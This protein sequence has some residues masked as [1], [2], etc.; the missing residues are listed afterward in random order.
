MNIFR[1]TTNRT[2]GILLDLEKKTMQFWLNGKEHVGR[3]KSLTEGYWVPAIRIGGIDN[4]V[5]L[6]PYGQFQQCIIPYSCS[7]PLPIAIKQDLESYLASWV[8]V[9]SLKIV[10]PFTNARDYLLSQ[11]ATKVEIQSVLA[12]LH[13]DGKPTGDVLVKVSD[14]IQFAAD[15]SSVSPIPTVIQA[16][17]MAQL[18]TNNKAS[19]QLDVLKACLKMRGEAVLNEA[20]EVVKKIVAKQ[21]VKEELAKLSTIAIGKIAYS[22]ASEEE[23][24]K[25]E[26]L[27]YTDKLLLVGKTSL[28]LLSREAEQ[29]LGFD[30]NEGASSFYRMSF[31]P[32]SSG[33]IIKLHIDRL[34]GIQLAS[35]MNWIEVHNGNYEIGD[36]LNSF[37]LELCLNLGNGKSREVLIPVSYLTAKIVVDVLMKSCLQALLVS[38]TDEKLKDSIIKRMESPSKI[39]KEEGKAPGERQA[40]LS[41]EDLHLMLSILAKLDEQLWCLAI[42]ESSSDEICALWNVNTS[43]I[44]T[45][46]GRLSS[47]VSWPTNGAV[48]LAEAGLVNV[49]DKRIMLKHFMEP[50][51]QIENAMQYDQRSRKEIWSL[52]EK[53]FPNNRQLRSEPCLNVPLSCT[54][55]YFPALR[56]TNMDKKP[57]EIT[58]VEYK[59]NNQYILTGSADG[60]VNIW[61][62]SLRLFKVVSANF[63]QPK[64]APLIKKTVVVP[65]TVTVAKETGDAGL[66][67][68]LFEVEEKQLWEE[69]DIELPPEEVKKEE[70]KKEEKKKEEPKKVVAPRQDFVDQL[71]AMGFPADLAKKALI[72]VNNESIE[73]ATEAVF[74][75][76]KKEPPRPP[77][78]KVEDK[79]MRIISWACPTCTLINVEGKKVCEVCS[80]EAPASA[81]IQASPNKEEKK[82]QQPEP[83]KEI[84]LGPTLKEKEETIQKERE[85][86]NLRKMEEEKLISS[87]QVKGYTMMTHN[88]YPAVPFTI[89]CALDTGKGC[90]IRVRTFKYSS[91]YLRSFITHPDSK[92]CISH[93]TDTWMRKSDEADINHH[94]F[95]ECRTLIET[96]IPLFVKNGLTG[97]W[98]K[99]K[100]KTEDA[101]IMPSEEI[102]IPCACDSILSICS[103]TTRI[104]KVEE[105]FLFALIKKIINGKDSLVLLKIGIIPPRNEGAKIEYKILKEIEIP[106]SKDAKL[107]S[108]NKSILVVVKNDE[109][110][111]VNTDKFEVSRK[112]TELADINSVQILNEEIED[113]T[114]NDLANIADSSSM[115]ISRIEK[116]QRSY[117]VYLTEGAA[118]KYLLIGSSPEKKGPVKV[119]DAV[120]SLGDL[121]SL[122][123]EIVWLN[124]LLCRKQ[125]ILELKI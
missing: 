47:Y 80:T 45:A 3:Q 16:S 52:L 58:H 18:L 6:N 25:V 7:S 59:T 14:P 93:L 57:E 90:Y 110:L 2:I 55:K 117:L 84:A 123:P 33:E 75:L 9:M 28:K 44:H 39:S 22:S 102:D 121:A 65:P 74:E 40:Q 46:Y 62:T 38:E 71:V 77:E 115:N 116:S 99:E 108:D 122:H 94:L 53:N 106:I 13:P 61:N 21:E 81:Y 26:Y 100:V 124:D 43:R 49:G 10:S 91:K 35:K 88:D 79:A 60:S 51:V 64:E 109:S 113:Y 87:A 63:K 23:V 98:T 66:F 119:T 118:K 89:A 42:A 34:E 8:L 105:N 54:L 86:E 48:Q 17:E 95:G 97:M 114:Q 1:T 82:T 72:S 73:A 83:P 32:K 31:S 50:G 107:L 29:T 4:C 67:H 111:I 104:E 120:A 11:I 19:S 76:Q 37:Y 68:D 27:P 101:Y 112:I 24:Q 56:H 30:M 5:I 36:Y 92:G 103:S 125:A 78:K 20:G 41:I 96:Y 69:D 15:C 85:M 12:L 70:P